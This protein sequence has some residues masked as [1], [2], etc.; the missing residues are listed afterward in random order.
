MSVDLRNLSI[1]ELEKIEKG[2]YKKDKRLQKEEK[3]KQEIIAN[4][5]KFTSQ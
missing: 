5:K 3:R 4:I 1:A 2:F